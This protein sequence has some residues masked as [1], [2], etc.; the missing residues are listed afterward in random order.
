[1]RARTA[2]DHEG[3]CHAEGKSRQE[4]RAIRHPLPPSWHTTVDVPLGKHPTVSIV[5]GPK[6]GQAHCSLAIHGKHVQSATATGP[7]GRAT[8]SGTL[9]TAPTPSRGTDISAS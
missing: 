8:C 3:G 7:F 4:P 6:G 1:M 5:L 2:T 9:P